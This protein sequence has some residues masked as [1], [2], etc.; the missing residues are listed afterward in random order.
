[1]QISSPSSKSRSARTM[2]RLVAERGRGRGRGRGR[3][4]TVG[5]A[6]EEEVEVEIESAVTGHE[7]VGDEEVGG[8]A[9][10]A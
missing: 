9:L 4:L 6:A 7:G 8:V 2:S 5:T 1:M 3:S 10:D